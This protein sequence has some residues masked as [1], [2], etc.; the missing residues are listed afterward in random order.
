MRNVIITGIP[1]SGTTLTAALIDSLPDSVCLNEPAWQ[2]GRRFEHPNDYARWLVGDFLS[3]RQKLLSGEPVKERRA[4]NHEPL[5]NYFSRDKSGAMLT[6]F[7]L[8]D[9]TRTGLS[10]DFLLAVKHN[11][12]YLAVLKA[13][14]DIGWF[15]I[16]AIVRHPVEVI[17]SWRNLDLPISRG[18][19]P[20]AAPYWPR[21]AAIIAEPGDLL[22]KQVKI[23]DLMCR[24]IHHFR[25]QIHVL[26]YEELITSPQRLS[27]YLGVADEPALPL[28]NKAPKEIPASER[29]LISAAVEKHGEFYRNFYPAL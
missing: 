2:V 16:I 5:T 20:G 1:R 25:S 24:R 26:S 13:L 15:T 18:E 12:P 17:Y 19:M 28:I 22:E 7:D 9:F 4:K 14:I 21:M 8:V 23:Y 27:E 3:L 6:H 29:A 10:P 11:G